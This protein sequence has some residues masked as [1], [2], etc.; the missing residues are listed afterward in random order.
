MPLKS[1]AAGGIGGLLARTDA[2]SGQSGCY[3][4]DGNGNVTA[5]VNAQQIVVAKYIY[6][7]FGNTLSKSGPLAD[8]NT[9]RFSSKDYQ[10]NSRLYHYGY[11]FYDPNLQ[12]WLNRDPIGEAGGINLYD[13]VR[14]DP[15]IYFDHLGL[16][17]RKPR[18][19]EPG[20]VT[21]IP[22]LPPR[23]PDRHPGKGPPPDDGRAT[24]VCDGNG[25]IRIQYPKGFDRKKMDPCVLECAVKHE[26]CHKQE[27][28]ASNPNVCAG[29]PDGTRISAPESVVNQSEVRCSQVELDCLKERKGDCSC[30]DSAINSRIPQVEAYRDKYKKLLGN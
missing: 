18:I 15:V 21:P 24:I 17:A 14:N 16:Q 3:H 30:S 25:G 22:A 5:M 7:P 1:K 23:P 29:Q 26:P 20:Y 10:A 2:T 6:D 9:H 8:A 19:G 27:A 4:V 28:L 12:R 11:R 13:F